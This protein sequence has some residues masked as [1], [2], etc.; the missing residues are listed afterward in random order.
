MNKAL[1]ELIMCVLFW[2]IVSIVMFF[3]SGDKKSK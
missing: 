3:K 2:I 1:E